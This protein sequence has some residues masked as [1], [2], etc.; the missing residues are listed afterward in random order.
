MRICELYCGSVA[1]WQSGSLK[2]YVSS[3]SILL[4]PKRQNILMLRSIKAMHVIANHMMGVQFSPQLKMLIN[5]CLI[6]GM[7]DALVSKTNPIK[8]I[9]SS[10]ILGKEGVV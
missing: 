8:G 7:A 9:G 10:P 1:Q 4:I 3:S 6:G 5:V 2:S